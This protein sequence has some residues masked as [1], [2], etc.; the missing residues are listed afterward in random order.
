ML[1]T[2][3]STSTGLKFSD[4]NVKEERYARV[5]ESKGKQEP[6]KILWSPPISGNVGMPKIRP[7]TDIR[8]EL[9]RL[10]D[11]VAGT[12]CPLLH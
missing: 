9:P 12:S 6:T 7:R 4:K 11:L 10:P 1:E 8:Q 2:A 5:G 3:P